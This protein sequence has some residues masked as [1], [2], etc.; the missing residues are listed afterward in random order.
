MI[1][2]SKGRKARLRRPDL[3]EVEK[4]VINVIEE[5]YYLNG[6]PPTEREIALILDFSNGYIHQII[7]SCINKG[8]ISH[9]E[10]K[11]RWHIYKGSKEE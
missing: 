4:T 2:T 8:Y 11:S 3:T 7:H 10:G 9:R 5:F 1:T 6:L